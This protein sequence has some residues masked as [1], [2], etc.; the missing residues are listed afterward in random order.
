[1]LWKLICYAP[2]IPNRFYQTSLTA[3]AST[4]TF[5]VFDQYFTKGNLNVNFFKWGSG[6]KKV[7][8]THGWGSKAMDFYDLISALIMEKDYEVWSFD[9]PGNGSSEGELSNL[10]LYIE[11]I[12]EFKKTIGIP[13]VMIG[14]SLGGMANIIS[15][16]QSQESPASL[17]SIAPLL[18]LTENF[19][20]SMSSVNVS[21]EDQTRFLTEFEQLFQRKTDDFNIIDMEG[22]TKPINHLLLYDSN[23]SIAPKT[24]IQDYL[25]KCPLVTSS[26]FND[27]SHS[28]IISDQRVIK[29]ITTFMNINCV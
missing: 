22:F 17:I 20:A 3:D 11:C 5:Q 6:S 23:D 9:A 1:M 18:N 13:D 4:L 19:K 16:H 28:K 7:L 15:I 25:Q 2:K 24:H 21:E 26:C 8:L 10:Y 12:K 14:H 27:S 29:Q